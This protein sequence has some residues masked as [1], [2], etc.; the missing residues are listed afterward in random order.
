M[1][2]KVVFLV[3]MNAFFISC[4]TTRHPQ[5][6]EK[7]AAVA[8]DPKNRTGIILTANYEARKY[9]VRTAMQV[10]EARKLCPQIVLIAPD[11][12]FYRQKSHEV[13]NVLMEYTPI[14]EQNSVDEAWLDMTGSE[15][16]FGQPLEVAKTIMSHINEECGLWCSIGIS[17]NKFLSKMA[18]D[19]KKPQGIT[20]LW[21]KDIKKKLW[22]L[23]VRKMYGIGNQTA[24][25]LQS[26]GIFTIGDIAQYS[27]ESLYKKFGKIGS[28][29]YL[30]AN[31]ID[32]SPVVSHNH[33]DVKSIG[34]SVTLSKDINNVEDAKLVLMKLA[35]EVGIQARKQN[36]KGRTIQIIIKYS[37]FQT[38]TRQKTIEPTNLTTIIYD[39][40][41][42]LLHKYWD[43]HKSV[44]LLG[45][46]LNNFDEKGHYEQ[47]SM[48]DLPKANVP[49]DNLEKTA[50]L[51]KALDAIREKYGSSTINRASLLD[52][53][54][55][56]KEK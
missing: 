10:H 2:N 43:P 23:P 4:E 9:G 31:G 3:D 15:R 5:I 44:R 27:R 12:S 56:S 38:I 49:K 51:E 29:V 14:I 41:I 54:I 53:N 37:N 30:L 21:Q 35:D 22:P 42:E 45:I 18:S 16:I 8:G 24:K 32:S 55:G 20:E 17:E 28:Q 26:I 13:M 46:S 50:K 1:Q 25:K 47:I 52:K 40:G 7:P 39:T 19:M 48:F 6:I 36:K 34:R 33:D 11:H